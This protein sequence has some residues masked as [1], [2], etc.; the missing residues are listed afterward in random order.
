MSR[1]RAFVDVLDEMLVDRATVTQASSPGAAR[2]A[3]QTT[4]TPLFTFAAHSRNRFWN[5][6]GPYQPAA[7]SATAGA[8]ASTTERPRAAVPPPASTLANGA[9]AATAADFR[10]AKTPVTPSTAT[11]AE[12]RSA[13]NLKPV[14]E[15]ALQTL[16]RLG[17]ALDRSFTTRELRSTFR[18]LAQRYHPDRHP[19]ASDLERVRLGATFAELTSAYGVLN[20]AAN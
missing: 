2:H 5:A 1:W 3:T 8:T 15:T 14:E 20:D 12:L 13:R 7:V 17:A 18:S 11:E 4:T 19:H 16:V 10:A 6:P 9:T